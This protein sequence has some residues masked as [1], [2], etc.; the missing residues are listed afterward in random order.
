VAQKFLE[1]AQNFLPHFG[2]LAILGLLFAAGVGLPFPEELTQLTAGFLAHEGVLRLGPAIAVCWIG[3]VG[4]D[5]T[6][7]FIARHAGPRVLSSR[8][9]ARFLTPARREWL[10]RHFARHAFWTVAISRHASGL[11]LAAF[12]LA[13]VHGVS[14]LTFVL[15]DGLSAA[16][17]VPLVV[18]AGYLFS[19]HLAE[20]HRDLRRVEIGI[21][22]AL[23]VGVA[24]VSALRRR[25]R[26]SVGS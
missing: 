24:V 4:G 12:A 16:V 23:A 1:A 6:W 18:G 26:R 22:V 3:I 8:Y 5:L 7:F 11:R 21:L 19:H 9:V 20:V 14:P 25:R 10:D 17:S 2:Y 15:A 13:A